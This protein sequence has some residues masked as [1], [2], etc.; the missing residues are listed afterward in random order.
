MSA[1]P[2]ATAAA[3]RGPEPTGVVSWGDIW[4]LTWPLVL[5]MIVNAAIGLLDTWVAGRVGPVAQ[6]AVGLVMQLILLINAT[7]TAV[8]IGAQALVSRFV[9]A[10]AW[11]DAGRAAQQALLLGLILSL[12]VMPPMWLLAPYFFDAMGAP[13]AVR[14]TGTWYL[15]ALLL[16][17]LPMD[18]GIVLSAIFRARGR[19]VALFVANLAEGVLWMAG[20]L[21][22]GL[23]L[24]WGL[25]G[26]ATGFVA[27]K[28]ANVLI[29]FAILR[30]MSL[31]RSIVE[32]WR[33]DWG[34]F[35]RILAIGLPAGAQVLIRN[36]GM[37]AYFGILGLL[38]RPTEAVAAFSIGFRIESIAF[39]PVF[40]LNIATATL[41]GQ[42]L[43]AGRPDHA[44]S[45]VWRIVAVGSSVM[46]AFGVLFWLLADGLA[47]VFTTDP[48]VRGFVADYLRVMAISEP[49]L[50]LVMVINGGLQGA[51][52]ARA[53]MV[54]VFL[55]QILLRLPLAVGLA[56]WLGLGATG[57]WWAMT[58]SMIAQGLGIT[59][60]F[61]LGHWRTREI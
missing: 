3:E 22:L 21:V 41:V 51:G 30:Q 23:W 36:L 56:L 59:W 28:L 25:V 34:W 29:G 2:A 27:G 19:T 61:R 33:V 31:Y 53:P 4:R 9:G 24:G 60:Y 12:L 39:L 50:A 11:P 35:R 46:G 7:T 14:E 15:R 44:E 55:F 40:A 42:N 37:M 38:A 20:S 58:I 5:T 48:V 1:P 52:D 57:A 49:F 16:A 8:A 13:P 6:A 45:V 32:P 43:G 47:A 10:R 17:L 54:A 18:L 26:L